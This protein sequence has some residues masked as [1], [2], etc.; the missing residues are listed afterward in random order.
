[1]LPSILHHDNRRVIHS[2]PNSIFFSC[3]GCSTHVSVFLVQCCCNK[4]VEQHDFR[5]Y[6]PTHD[7]WCRRCEVGRWIGRSPRQP[8]LSESTAHWDECGRIKNPNASSRSVLFLSVGTVRVEDCITRTINRRRMR[9]TS[10][11]P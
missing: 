5:I 2:Q 1:M 10:L 6:Y 4:H 11:G 9:C 3:G 8:L 7:A